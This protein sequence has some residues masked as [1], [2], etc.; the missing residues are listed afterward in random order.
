MV[1]VTASL[2]CNM[3][4]IN[5]K[6]RVLATKQSEHTLKCQHTWHRRFGHRYAEDVNKLQKEELVFGLRIEDCGIREAC[7][8]CI[9][10]KLPRSPIPKESTTRSTSVL[11]LL[12]TDLCGPMQ[13]ETPS[14]KRYFITFIDDFSKY[15]EVW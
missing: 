13:T 5:V 8:C 1:I 14:G 11:E 12:H 15:T 2:L 4:T 3:Y 7:K 10:G 6:H 9:K